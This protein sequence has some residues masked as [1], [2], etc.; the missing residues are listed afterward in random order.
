ML[1]D[2]PPK[3]IYEKF[4]L[5]CFLQ[6]TLRIGGFCGG[7][8]QMCVDL[9]QKLWQSTSITSFI[10]L[11][12]I[13]WFRLRTGMRFQNT[14]CRGTA[15]GSTRLISSV[16]RLRRTPYSCRSLV[17]LC[18]LRLPWRQRWKRRCPH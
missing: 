16:R 8:L 15:A 10:K 4:E 7:A 6:P 17:A 2:Q 9:C 13:W 12:C 3:F 1:R 14:T 11:C 5:G 18:A